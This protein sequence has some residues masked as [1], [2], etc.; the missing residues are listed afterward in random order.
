MSKVRVTITIE[1]SV[2]ERIDRLSQG[3]SRSEM[4]ERALKH[5]LRDRRFRALEKGIAAYYRD[6]P[7]ADGVENR[8]WAEHSSRQIAKTWK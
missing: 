7:A 5:W 3:S 8:E 6:Q 1:A 2:L 4:F